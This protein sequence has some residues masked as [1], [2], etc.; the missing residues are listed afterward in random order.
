LKKGNR[1]VSR[2]KIFLNI[3]KS[4]KIRYLI[5]LHL[6]RIVNQFIIYNKKWLIAEPSKKYKKEY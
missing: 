3:P 1:E 6:N 2:Q 4:A 5:L